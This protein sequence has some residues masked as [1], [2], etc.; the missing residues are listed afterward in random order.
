MRK[1]VY[2]KTTNLKPPS[3]PV[4]KKGAPKKLKPTPSDNSTTQSPSFFEHVDNF[5][6]D[7]PIPKSQKRVFKWALIRKP[8]PPPKISFINEMSVFGTNTLSVSSM[9]RGTVIVVMELFR[10][11]YVKENINIHLFAIN[12][13]VTTRIIYI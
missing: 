4:K 1:I 11:Y 5:Y 9:L 6:S 12:L 10:F 3:Q 8:P 7:S 13:S 2:P